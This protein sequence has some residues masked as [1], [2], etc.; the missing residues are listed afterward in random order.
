V[1]EY[2]STELAVAR[3]K[4]DYEYRVRTA[5]FWNASGGA[6]TGFYAFALRLTL[7]KTRL[8]PYL[9]LG[10]GWSHRWRGDAGQSNVDLT[11]GGPL[12]TLSAGV[13]WRLQRHLLVSMDLTLLH[14]DTE[15]VKGN[16]SGGVD[17]GFQ[18]SMASILVGVR[19]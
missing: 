19:F 5:P 10:A 16:L 15:R 18:R 6:E 7:L 3:E 11:R 17:L 12:G 8:A 13:E 2:F 14:Y 4:E 9:S 1:T